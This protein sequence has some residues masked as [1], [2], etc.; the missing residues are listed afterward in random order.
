MLWL[1]AQTWQLLTLSFLAGALVT[2]LALVRGGRRA[3]AMPSTAPA[4]AG[5][6]RGAHAAPSGSGGLGCLDPDVPDPDAPL[7]AQA[8]PFDD[9]LDTPVLGFAAPVLGDSDAA[10][11]DAVDSAASDGVTRGEEA[12]GAGEPAPS[13]SH[14]VKGDADAL[15]YY[16]PSAPAYRAVHAAVWFGT[17][18][19]AQDA[20]FRPW[21]WHARS[22]AAPGDAGVVHSAPAE[23]LVSS[24]GAPARII[25]HST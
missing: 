20:G 15:L 8:E 19:E 16:T 2:W 10:G 18:G 5:S 24:T 3:P 17:E 25:A 4:M 22:L 23:T 7:G 1:F 9:D 12:T 6:P 14:V 11:V 21:D 13:H